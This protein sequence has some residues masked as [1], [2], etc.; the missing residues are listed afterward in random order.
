MEYIYK[1]FETIDSTNNF[2]KLNCHLFD[3]D[4]ITLI[5]AK[6]Q[7]AGRGRFKREW[8]SPPL[9]NIYATFC[10]AVKKGRKDIGNI[11]QLLGLSAAKTLKQLH[12]SP[13]LKWPNDILLSEKK[14]A[15]ILCETVSFDDHFMVILGI[16][17]NVNM[18]LEVLQAIDHPATS[19]KIETGKTFNV[20]KVLKLLKEHF[21]N[22]LELFLK[23][24]FNSFLPEYKKLIW[25]NSKNILRFHDTVNI[26]EGTFHSIN[27]DGTLNLKLIDGSIKTFISGEFIS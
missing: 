1:H 7:T 18:P 14:I 19:L 12:L 25:T 5:T 2:G 22:D 16:G 24:G 10:F 9:E 23:N 27:D 26:V 8:V 13:N 6:T 17:L 21:A 4:K 20:D 15:G 11:P 3:Q